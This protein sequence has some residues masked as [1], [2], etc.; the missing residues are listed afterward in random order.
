LKDKKIIVSSFA[1]LSIALLPNSK[2]IENNYYNLNKINYYNYD[3]INNYYNVVLHLGY[4]NINKEHIK[5][6]VDESKKEGLDI[7][8]VLALVQEESKFKYN[9]LNYNKN[10]SN[11]YGYFQ[12][13]NEYHPQYRKDIKKHI[14]Y[15]VKFLKYCIERENYNLERALSRYNS[16]SPVKS[17]KYAEKILKNK[18]N[19]ERIYYKFLFLKETSNEA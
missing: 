18:D 2:P 15:G 19:I 10:G 1:I 12:I 13:N 7:F 16:G 9:A 11:D 5:I 8:L 3:Y 6:I 4:N 17:K 14:Q